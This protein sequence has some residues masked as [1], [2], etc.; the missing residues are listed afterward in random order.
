MINNI[1]HV[2]LHVVKEDVKN[3][4]SEVLN[5]EIIRTFI[6]QPEDSY[7]IF[8]IKEKVQIL[9][10][11]CG[12]IDL[13]LFIG[14]KIESPSFGHICLQSSEAEEIFRK[15]GK[16]GYHTF[17]RKR[18]SGETYFISDSNYNLFEIKTLNR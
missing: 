2:G 1:L 13:E 6:L 18:N 11:S 14:N 9:Y 12:S 5:C 4:Y 16:K 15:A 10:T 8:G 7:S 17:I 3:F